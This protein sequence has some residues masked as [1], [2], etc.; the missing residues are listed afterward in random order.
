MQ[1]QGEEYIRIQFEGPRNERKIYPVLEKLLPGT[2]V[3]PSPGTPVPPSPGTPVPPPRNARS[4]SPERPFRLPIPAEPAPP[5]AASPIFAEGGI[6]LDSHKDSLSCEPANLPGETPSPP[7]PRAPAARERKA[8]AAHPPPHP[9]ESSLSP[10]DTGLDETVRQELTAALTD[11][12]CTLLQAN[13]IL[14]HYTPDQVRALLAQ[15]AARRRNGER[16][17]GMWHSAAR[18]E[19]V[20]DLTAGQP[21]PDPGARA[22]VDSLAYQ[23]YLRACQEEATREE[24]AQALESARARLPWQLEAT[25]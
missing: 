21:P 8:P 19:W 11:E 18:G 23:E 4:A 15:A 10:P 12:G 20:P 14:H 25:P 16:N 3:P 9:E 13:H 1:I 5:E 7:A 22:Y 2:P 6:Q 17:G 24:T